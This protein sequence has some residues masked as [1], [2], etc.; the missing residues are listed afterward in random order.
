MPDEPKFFTLR[1]AEQVRQEIEPILIDAMEARRDAAGLQASLV[2]LAGR[3]LAAGGLLVRY[4][5]AAAK[6]AT[7][8]KL[9]Q[10]IESALD[11]IHSTGCVVKDLDSGLLDFPSMLDDQ[12]VY[13][14]WRLGEDR[15]RYYHGLNEGFAG[16]KPIDPHDR[17]PSPPF[18]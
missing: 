15:I 3:I 18:H 4:E 6:R 12:E 10:R 11:Q 2:R 1:E 7:L 16:R 14:C 17:G 9:N 13:L 8:D 5:E